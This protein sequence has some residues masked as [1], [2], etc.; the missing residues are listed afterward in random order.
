MAARQK[1]RKDKKKKKK[2]MQ[3]TN[4]LKFSPA[5]PNWPPQVKQH[6]AQQLKKYQYFK[7]RPHVYPCDDF[8]SLLN[9]TIAILDKKQGDFCW[10]L[11]WDALFFSQLIYNGFLTI[12]SE[13]QDDLYV[14]LPK[15][16]KERCII[17]L[18][19]D[20]PNCHLP[21]P[22]SKSTKKRSKNYTVT[23]DQ[24]FEEVFTGCIN[25][26]GLNWLYPPMQAV[27]YALFHN[28][29]SPQLNG[30]TAHSIEIWNENGELIAGELGT[31]V[32]SIYTS[33]T[34]YYL[35]SGTGSIQ[36]MVLVHLLQ[37]CG[38]LL[39]D[40]GMFIEYKSSLGA[41]LLKR[42]EFLNK[43]RTLRQGKATLECEQKTNCRDIVNE[44]INAASKGANVEQK[45]DDADDGKPAL[46]RKAQKRLAKKEKRRLA[47]LKAKQQKEKQQ[48]Q[49]ADDT[50]DVAMN[51][52]T[53]IET[54]DSQ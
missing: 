28:R 21:V 31:Q 20:S 49:N 5:L 40:L 38:F 11:D 27:L 43:Y 54:Q 48:I 29:G 2:E 19:V 47:K 39:W 52:D 22:V 44:V 37:K 15:L 42:N 10:S 53:A 36:L 50:K 35:E 45:I 9:K 6:I 1:K 3:K 25:Q 26:H 33:L 41:G 17:D 7:K 4:D 51:D 34:G 8:E 18:D 46:S 12:A 23:V 32:G 30:V 13:I 16:H 24:C 14:M